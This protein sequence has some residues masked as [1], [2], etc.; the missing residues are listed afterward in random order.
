[1][2][3]DT[4]TPDATYTIQEAADRLHVHR[5][6]I[7]ALPFFRAR[8]VKVG[9]RSLLLAADVDLFLTLHRTGVAA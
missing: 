9:R 5:S 2:R 1:M 7:Y 8:I 3:M 4:P 6:T